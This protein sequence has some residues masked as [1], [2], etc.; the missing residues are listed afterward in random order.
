[1]DED[2]TPAP[3]DAMA[4]WTIKSFPTA[5][6]NKITL[7]ARK[8]GLTVG[9]WVERRVEEWEEM[10][11]PTRVDPGLQPGQPDLMELVTAARELASGPD[12]ALLKL[13]RSAVREQLQG[14]RRSKLALLPK[15]TMKALE[16]PQ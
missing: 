6:R 5:T 3:A 10:G 1:M 11:Q 13:A 7:F 9:Q 14:L 4:P 8:E 15:R 12:D 16:A 2:N